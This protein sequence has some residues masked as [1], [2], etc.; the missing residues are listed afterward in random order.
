MVVERD[1][2]DGSPAYTRDGSFKLDAVGRI[3][4]ASGL[5]LVIER[6]DPGAEHFSPQGPGEFTVGRN[7]AIAWQPAGGDPVQVGY[8]RLAVPVSTA[9]GRDPDM[10]SLGGN[11]YLPAEGSSVEMLPAGAASAGQIRQGYLE[12]SNV[13]LADEMVEM[14]IAQRAYQLSARAVQAADTMLALANGIR[15]G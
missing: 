12:R 1:D 15:R 2:G 11:L 4:T 14:I 7:G 9:A 8:I 5:P 6:S 10:V 3:V 13:S